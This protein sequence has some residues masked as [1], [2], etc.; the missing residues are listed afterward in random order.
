MDS[1]NDASLPIDTW[2][3]DMQAAIDHI[4]EI[5]QSTLQTHLQASDQAAKVAGEWKLAERLEDQRVALNE[6][7]A[8]ARLIIEAVE[9]TRLLMM[10]SEETSPATLHQSLRDCTAAIDASLPKIERAFLTSRHSALDL[11]RWTR[12]S[13]KLDGSQL[14][15]QYR[16]SY[17]T[18]VEYT[19]VFKPRMEAM[20]HDLLALRHDAGLHHDVQQLVSALTRYNG[21]AESARR[22]VKSIV[23]PPLELVFHDTQTFHLDW[24]PLATEEQSRLATEFNDCCQL[25]LY[26]HASFERRVESVQPDLADGVE[27]SL[28]VLPI[29]HW[30]VLFTV[31]ED[32]V[33]KELTVTLLRVVRL[34]DF[35]QACRSVIHSLYRDLTND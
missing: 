31:D 23:E 17:A 18:L 21:V 14:P 29:D 13:G 35:D 33:F 28:Y 25:L 11:L 19:P 6:L 4:C 27:A 26:D 5:G 2:S 7:F 20:Q 22:F 3:S 34:S 16:S 12:R 24:Q 1:A 9:S 8:N 30:R 15:A 32:P 10:S